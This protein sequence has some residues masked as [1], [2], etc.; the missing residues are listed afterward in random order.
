MSGFMEMWAQMG[1]LAKAIVAVLGLMS[2]WSISVMIERYLKFSAARKQAFTALRG[3]GW[4][5]TA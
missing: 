3:C 1:F 2:I 4:H 5:S